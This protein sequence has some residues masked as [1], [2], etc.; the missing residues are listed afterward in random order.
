[1]EGRLFGLGVGV[2]VGVGYATWTCEG[3]VYGEGWGGAELARG[4]RVGLV[5]NQI[6]SYPST[7]PLSQI[8]NT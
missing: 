4:G 7:K 2:G 1:M 5:L 3:D 6:S 8:L